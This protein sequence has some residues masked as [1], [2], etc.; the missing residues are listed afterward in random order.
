M[1]RKDFLKSS[2]GV[3]GFS[4]VLIEACK[5]DV[6]GTTDTTDNSDTSS[7]SCAVATEETAGPYPE[8][9]SRNSAMFRQNIT[10]GKTG[11]PLSLT[12]TVV[13]TNSNCAAI[14]NARVD[15]WHCDKDGYYSAYS[16]TGYLGTQNNVG[17]TFLRGIQLTDSNGQVTFTTIYP[18]WYSGRA[19]HIHVEVFIDSVLKATTQ[20]AFADDLNTTVYNTSLYSAH[21]QNTITNETDMVFSDSYEKELVTTT[22]D[23]T[24]GYTATYTIGLAL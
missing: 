16:N 19:T 13:N 5:K 12:L 14:E 8:D 9:L 22:G 20:L 23:T 21:G 6:A 7:D 11:I 4:A 2:L 18:G 17:K 10:D 15:I 1:E 24:N 3:L